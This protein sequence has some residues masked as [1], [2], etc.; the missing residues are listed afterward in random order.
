MLETNFD[1]TEMTL[2][3]DNMS[4]R[5]SRRSNRDNRSEF[6]NEETIVLLDS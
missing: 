1:K 3:G 2:G 5:G 4:R 6:G